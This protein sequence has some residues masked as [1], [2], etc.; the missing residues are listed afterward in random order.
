MAGWVNAAKFNLEAPLVALV[1]GLVI[2]NAV[3]LPKWMDSSIQGRVFREARL[4]FCWARLFP[5]TLVLTAGPIAIMQATFISLVTC[6]VIYF[7]RDQVVRAG[8]TARGRNRGRR[9]GL[10]G[11]CLD[12]DCR[13]GRGEK[14]RSLH[15]G[16]AGGGLGAGDDPCSAVCVTGTGT[17]RRGGRC[18]T[19]P[20]SCRRSRI[21]RSQRLRKDGR[22]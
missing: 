4:S 9:I 15:L 14:G 7:T 6:L 21:C 16:H 18:W 3:T 8:P 10:R 5:I 12:G 20:P 13:I 2:S 22:P 1:A 19:A 17:F 11:F